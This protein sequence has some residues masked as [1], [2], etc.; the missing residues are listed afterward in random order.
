M[1]ENGIDII[2]K[3]KRHEKRK[4]NYFT[5]QKACHYDIDLIRN[6]DFSNNKF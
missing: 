3:A 6:V 4:L 2:S 5:G 1:H